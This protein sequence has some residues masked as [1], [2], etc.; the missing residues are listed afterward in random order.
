[1]GSYLEAVHERVVI[2]DGAVGTNLQLRHLGPDDFGGPALR[3][4]TRSWWPPA[5]T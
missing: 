3:A 2:F 1:M 4:A 5:R